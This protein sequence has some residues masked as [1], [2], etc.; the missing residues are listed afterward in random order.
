M[1]ATAIAIIGPDAFVGLLF[2]V[3]FF[4]VPLF[5]FLFC[6]GAG[7]CMC[8]ISV[9]FFTL[10]V[11]RNATMFTPPE[12]LALLR[13]AVATVFLSGATALLR[14]VFFV[15]AILLTITLHNPTDD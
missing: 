9:D 14:L 12:A 3:G 7:L 10:T 5:F 15:G 13:A 11:L 1:A 6:W 2:G 8:T 4:T